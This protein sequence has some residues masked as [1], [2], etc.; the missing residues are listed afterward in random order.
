MI[1]G[2][3]QRALCLL[4]SILLAAIITAAAI[5][6]AA[7][8]DAVSDLQAKIAE[9][10][11][12][13]RQLDAEITNYQGKISETDGQ[14]KTLRNAIASIDLQIKQLQL[15]TQS[16]QAKIGATNFTLQNLAVQI[17][18]ADRKITEEKNGIAASIRETNAGE[19]T[20]VIESFLSPNPLSS[21]WKT[22]NAASQLKSGLQKS[23]EN[24][25]DSQAKLKDSK[26][27]V[28]TQ[29]TKLVQYKS[30]LS[31]QQKLAAGTKKDKN[32]LL[33][34]T[35]EQESQYQ[36]LLAK[37]RSD[38]AAFENEL[39]QYESQLKIAIDPS[40]LPSETHN[41]L[42]WPLSSIRVTQLFGRTEDAK[43]LYVSGS[44]SGVDFAA[45]KGTKVFAA[46]SGTV[47]ATGNTDD[48]PGC[49]SYG[50]WVLIDHHDG[51]SS[52]YGHLSLIGV[53][54][55]Q[56]VAAGD[57]IGWSGMSGYATGPH[58]H[59]GVFA[60]QAMKIQRYSNSVHCQGATIPIAPTAGYLDPMMYLPKL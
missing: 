26:A 45:A 31:A 7:R 51:L 8:A 35:K 43:R 53:A 25:K 16:T 18:A 17:A 54:N 38:K 9:H 5:G 22:I 52:I 11:N 42:S 1:K 36:K 2:M 6:T 50:K 49:Y 46:G 3:K 23:L 56:N 60:T 33:A 48:F 27:S 14:A 4:Q 58:L 20:S 41:T 47:L 12:L 37:K 15:E 57:T 30:D 10:N 40:K 29:K 44:H 28:E 13:I 24:L 19:N 32:T 39:Y 55:G 59:F 21:A 34:Q